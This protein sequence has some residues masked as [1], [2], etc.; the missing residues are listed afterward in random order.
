[1]RSREGSSLVLPL[2]NL[3]LKVL[4]STRLPV[5]GNQDVPERKLSLFV[6]S[7]DLLFA[8]AL[9]LRFDGETGWSRS[10]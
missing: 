3:Q 1:M 8:R 9:E 6:C 2:T 4:A 5:E 7:D 10:A